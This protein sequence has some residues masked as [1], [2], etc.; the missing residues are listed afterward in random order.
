MSEQP[1]NQVPLPSPIENDPNVPSPNTPSPS[2]KELP[3]KPEFILKNYKQLTDEQITIALSTP[4]L[5]LHLLG[6][7]S[8]LSDHQLQVAVPLMSLDHIK[9]TI[10]K[11][12]L[13]Q[14][15]VAVQVMNPAQ[16]RQT[17][18]SLTSDDR[19]ILMQNITL[20]TSSSNKDE[21]QSFMAFVDPLAMCIAIQIPE[22]APKLL[23]AAGVMTIDQLK[24]IVPLLL[25]DQIRQ[26]LTVLEDETQI[27]TALGMIDKKDEICAL[28]GSDFARL[29]KK[30]AE[31][32][33]RF[34]SVCE[35]L[36]EI[37][38][39][40]KNLGFAVDKAGEYESIARTV[41]NTK[42]EIETLQQISRETQ[43][44]LKLPLKILD[45][46]E[47]TFLHYQQLS[48]E[49]SQLGKQLHGKFSNL[50]TL[51]SMLSQHWQQIKGSPDRSSKQEAASSERRELA[52]SIDSVFEDDDR[53]IIL[54][55][56]VKEIG[57]PDAVG[58]HYA[59]TWNDII[60]TGFRSSKEFKDNG[61]LTLEQLQNYIDANKSKAKL[62]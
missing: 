29:E 40:I 59:M 12:Q 21:L 45:S 55:E 50:D 10:P 16:V 57:N 13:Q 18:V 47:S 48:N 25:S 4:E 54:Y 52:N 28:L 53:A 44:A 39:R 31:M 35:Q 37:E 2:T 60:Q 43:A 58:N 30:K 36:P 23:E 5:V 17:V 7:V 56:A 62:S 42:T 41:R 3:I 14:T 19:N 26:L 15:G 34:R 33:P 11:L 8:K 32:G 20:L 49:I 9:T 27:S 24:V 1:N 46:T 22:L 51:I 61:I 38:V 6:V